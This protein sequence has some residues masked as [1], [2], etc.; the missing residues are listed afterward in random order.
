MPVFGLS[1]ERFDPDLALVE[2]PL[3]GKRLGVASHSFEVA[4]MERAMHLPI[5]VT[6]S[7][8]G[9]ERTSVTSRRLC[10]VFRLFC[11]VLHP[12]EMQWLPVGADVEIVRGVI[13]ELGGSI[14]RRHML[15]IRQ[16]DVGA[17]ALIFESLNILDGSIF[18]IAGDLAGPQMPAEARM[19]KQI[20][21]RQG[22][23]HLGGG[24]QR[25]QN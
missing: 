16:R 2:S 24:E 4:S 5:R 15:P 8:L 11:L 19:P 13:R 25:C 12:R 20:E 21:H 6:R 14:I 23:C 10:S 7:T 18:G 9:R 17:D 1:K 3:I 22:V